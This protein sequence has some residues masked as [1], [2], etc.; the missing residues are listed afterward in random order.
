[1]ERPAG[2]PGVKTGT[3]TWAR[4]A[5]GERPPDPT[6]VQRQQAAVVGPDSGSTTALALLTASTSGAGL[7]LSSAPVLDPATKAARELFIVSAASNARFEA[8]NDMSMYLVP[9]GQYNRNLERRRH[10]GLSW[11]GNGRSGAERCKNRRQPH[12][13]RPRVAEI[14]LHRAAVHRRDVERLE[15]GWNP[16]RRPRIAHKTTGKVSRKS[17]AIG[18]LARISELE[19]SLDDAKHADLL[20]RR[21]AIRPGELQ[22]S[23]E[24]KRSVF[25]MSARSA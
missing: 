19:R 17:N 9:I 11:L 4:L 12:R 3:L 1:M 2:Y 23:D 20:V 6:T 24:S 25:E 22:A 14:R 5:N 10:Q 15:Y 7:L 16:V 8:L 13:K 18:D 21:A